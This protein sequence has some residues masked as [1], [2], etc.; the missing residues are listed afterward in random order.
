MYLDVLGKPTIIFNSLKS[1]FDV[2]DNRASNS[3]GRPRFVVANDILNEGL[4]I[5]FLD[6]GEL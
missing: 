6:H 5:V 4:S 3:F 1:A 2:L